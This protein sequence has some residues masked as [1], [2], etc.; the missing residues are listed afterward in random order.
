MDE[1]NKLIFESETIDL[2]EKSLHKYDDLA[3][4]DSP[5]RSEQ[6]E[7]DF[8]SLLNFKKDELVVH[9]NHGIGKFLGLKNLSNTECFLIEYQNK[10]LLYVPVNSISQ[11]SPYIG[12]KDIPLDSL[13]KKKWS[14]K[15]QKSKLKAFDIASEILEAEAKR[16]L[17]ESQ[18]VSLDTTEYEKF[19]DTFK[20]T[21]TPDQARVIREVIADLLSDKPQDRLI[22]GEVGFGKTEIALRAS[23]IVAQNNY[24]VCILAPTTV[25]AKQH[26][27]VFKER[28][29]D[30]PQR[31]CLL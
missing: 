28:F 8:D 10:E 18:K 4:K 12:I 5:I 29:S 14:E 16:N 20:F 15:A 22:C 9:A 7:R 19:C 1:I 31:V 25:L 3:F 21:E 2:P 24:Q 6:L 27:E 11:I 30:F 26:F 17:E 13:S 23:F